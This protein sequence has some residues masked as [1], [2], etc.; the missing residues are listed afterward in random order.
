MGHRS[1]DGLDRLPVW[2]TFLAVHASGSLSG[3]A[4]TLGVTQPA[5]TAQLRSLEEV[6]GERLFERSARGVT[7]TPR[8]D[9]L[10]ARL[11][12]PFAAVAEAI[13]GAGAGD[14]GPHPP[15]RLG[16]A[17]DLLAEVVV[18]ALAPLVAAGVR[19][20]VVPGSSGA[21]VDS[22]RAG[23]LDLVVASERPRGRS[24][25]ATPLTD[26]T[27]ILVAAPGVAPAPVA[28][29][30]DLGA[31]PL[32]A[33]AHDVPILR[34]YWRHVFGA[35]LERE[36]ALTFPDLRALRE[37]AL[38]GAGATALPLHACREVLA[39]GRLVDLHPSDDP[40]INTLFLVRRSGAP[41]PHVER[42]R[43]AVTRAVIDA[44]S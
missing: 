7:P 5:V 31:V 1:A 15:V 23:V 13:G 36:P 12:G 22:L 25:L 43:A 18:P 37:A 9:E 2:R 26:E 24:V 3:A 4:R 11:A 28:S 17:A 32:L 40:P 34:R 16:G 8:A 42:V 33:Y 10:A 14:D 29:P 41:A 30:D 27:F 39:S 38:A 20:Q 44:L 6:L 35:R 21:L 19:L